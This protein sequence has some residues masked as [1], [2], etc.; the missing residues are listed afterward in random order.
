M[1]QEKAG[2]GIK[3]TE[4]QLMQMAQQE[5]QNLHAKQALLERVGNLLGETV[6]AKEI[7]KEIKSNNGKI[8]FNIGATVLIEA[9]I[10]NKDTCKR[11]LADNSY[12]NDSIEE[13][14]KWLEK[15]EEQIKKQ[16]SIVQDE[17]GASQKKLTDYVSLL[18]QID[19]EKRKR[20]QMAKNAPLTISK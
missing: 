2:K 19:A 9:Q 1:V 18:K 5:D 8:M 3:L 12:R 13:T 17:M 6:T 10:T 4:D 20:I 11:A 15:K 14:L 16:I 7:L